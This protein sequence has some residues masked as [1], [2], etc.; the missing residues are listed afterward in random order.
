LLDEGAC[1]LRVEGD[2]S[3]I[4]LLG[5]DLRHA[6]RPLELGVGCAQRVVQAESNLLRSAH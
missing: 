5:N 3:S 1:F 4:G 2:S 6:G